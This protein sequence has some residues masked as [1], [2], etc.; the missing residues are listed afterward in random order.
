[1]SPSFSFLLPPL[2]LGCA[3]DYPERQANIAV[4]CLRNL[5]RLETVPAHDGVLAIAAYGPSLRHGIHT[6][7]AEVMAGHAVMTVSGSHDFLISNGIVPDFHAELDPRERKAVF[8][9]NP[10][11]D[12]HYLLASVC[13]PR[14]F[15][16]LA[17][18][19]VSMWHLGDCDEAIEDIKRLEGSALIHPSAQAIGLNAIVLGHT[20]GYRRFSMHGF[21]CCYM[22]GE[23]HPGFHNG[24]NGDSN[25]MSV[26]CGERI[27]ETRPEWVQ[28][29]RNF[30][31]RMVPSLTDCEFV[32]HGNGLMAEMAKQGLKE[33]ASGSAAA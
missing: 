28:Y 5:P 9:A 29:A 6:M 17:R 19:N 10:R 11:D 23:A 27:F 8:V 13:H 16:N 26:R 2:K 7:R 33:A 14:V 20:L 22:D 21:D 4:N 1:M 30:F 3:V 32:I 31:S 18:C 25:R 15:E 12:I 24:S